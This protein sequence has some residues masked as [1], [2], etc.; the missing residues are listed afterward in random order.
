MRYKAKA[1]YAKGKDLAVA[2]ALSR[3]PIQI[4]PSPT[5]VEDVELHVHMVQ[6]NLPMSPQ[7]MA[8]LRSSTTDEATF[9]SSIVHT[10]TGWPDY[11]KDVPESLKVFFSVQRILSVSNGLLAYTDRIVIPTRLRPDILEKIHTCHQGVTKCLERAKVSV[12]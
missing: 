1:E 5:V 7:K 4:N 10:L 9:Q 2:D 11:E 3:S 8:E 6:S 12:W